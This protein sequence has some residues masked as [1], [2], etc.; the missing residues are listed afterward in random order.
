MKEV[1]I[2][3]DGGMVSVERKGTG[4]EL[5]VMENEDMGLPVCSKVVLDASA[6]TQLWLALMI[7]I[8]T[9]EQGKSFTDRVQEELRKKKE[10]GV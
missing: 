9:Q 7:M 10:D 3:V 4:V 2:R 8:N 5:A 6:V 1:L